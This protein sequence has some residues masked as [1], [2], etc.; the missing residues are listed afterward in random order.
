MPPAREINTNNPVPPSLA[1][2]LVGAGTVID[3]IDH[4]S[5]PSESDLVRSLKFLSF[6][7]TQTKTIH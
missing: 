7:Q 3:G 4:F 2:T 6:N 5:F 1:A